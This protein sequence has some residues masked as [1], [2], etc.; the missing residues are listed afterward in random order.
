[1]SRDERLY[2]EDIQLSCRKI[3]QYI[4]GFDFEAFI[5]DDRTYDAVIRNLEIIGEAARHVPETIQNK[6]PEVEWRAMAA[7]RN[8]VAHEYFGVKD[9]IIW[10]IL[11][12]KLGPL[13][14]S[15]DA[16]ISGY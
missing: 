4:E 12:Q 9:E 3:L 1:V 8:I 13:L 6:H 11:N 15:V 7:L 5:M 14:I 2:L 16:I 10:D